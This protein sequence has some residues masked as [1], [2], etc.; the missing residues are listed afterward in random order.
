MKVHIF[1]RVA[2]RRWAPRFTDWSIVKEMMWMKI[3]CRPCI[4]MMLCKATTSNATKSKQGHGVFMWSMESLSWMMTR[5][6]D[7]V[8]LTKSLVRSMFARR[9]RMHRISKSTTTV[10]VRTCIILGVLGDV[11]PLCGSLETNIWRCLRVFRN[12]KCSVSMLCGETFV[13]CGKT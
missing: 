4:Y 6:F 12:M 5:K 2:K 9:A 11:E 10:L 3:F 8:V 7:S 1:S 13:V